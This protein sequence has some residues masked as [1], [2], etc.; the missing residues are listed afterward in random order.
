MVEKGETTFTD[1]Y[2]A[3][4]EE[5]LSIVD[6]PIIKRAF[7]GVIFIMTAIMYISIFYLLIFNITIYEKY[8][9]HFSIESY[10]FFNGFLIFFLIFIIYLFRLIFLMIFPGYH[11][12]IYNDKILLTERFVGRDKGF[13]PTPKRFYSH[14]GVQRLKK[15]V[16]Y[17]RN[18]REVYAF[19]HTLKTRF[20]KGGCIVLKDLNGKWNMVTVPYTN[21]LE[22]VI[23]ELQFAFGTRWEGVFTGVYKLKFFY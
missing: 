21:K 23:K 11:F 3:P 5:I 19:A 17:F 9:K 14:F 15:C 4:N 10:Y 13:I 6:K 1:F 12:I 18:I 16:L 20:H 8:I 7:F 2:C 22:D